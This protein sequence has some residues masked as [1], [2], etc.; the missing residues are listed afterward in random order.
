MCIPQ[1]FI[2]RLETRDLILYSRRLRSAFNLLS[3]HN[4]K[5]TS[6]WA[7]DNVQFL[8]FGLCLMKQTD[9]EWLMI[10]VWCLVLDTIFMFMFIFIACVVCSVYNEKASMHHCIFPHLLSPFRKT[11]VDIRYLTCN[12][13]SFFMFKKAG[14]HKKIHALCRYRKK[15]K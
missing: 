15:Y 7:M 9:T 14:L 1:R 4:G 11:P 10:G 2:S 8:F 5:R 12:S 13:M 6:I 3:I